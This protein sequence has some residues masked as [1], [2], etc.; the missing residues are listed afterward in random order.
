MIKGQGRIQILINKK[1]AE[2]YKKQFE[3]KLSNYNFETLKKVETR[4]PLTLYAFSGNA[5]FADQVLSI[6]SFLKNVG[7]PEKWIIVSDGTHNTSQIKYF[8]SFPF[9][10]FK[11]WH[12]LIAEK[13]RAQIADTPFWQIKK[14]F[15]VTNIPIESSTVV[16]DSDI[17]FFP[18]F[19]D[20]IESLQEKNWYLSDLT[21]HFDEGFKPIAH[22]NYANGGF[23]IL[24]Q[25]INWEQGIEYMLKRM[26]NASI[27]HFTEQT[28]VEI[29]FKNNDL[30]FL[31]PR[32]FLLDLTDQFTIKSCCNSDNLAIR[33]FVGPIRFRMWI[34]A[35]KYLYFL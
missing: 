8:E 30:N 16:L 25:P 14:F 7:I 2:L 11:L 23:Y 26:V 24:N 35:N 6:L 15:V 32:L 12:N 29:V 22:Q 21:P 31:D 3:V 13:F 28:A 10:K 5:Q 19:R 27:S 17:L 20:C 18:K 9:I 4:V 33:H 34:A 1:R